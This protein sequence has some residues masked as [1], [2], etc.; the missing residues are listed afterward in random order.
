MSQKQSVSVLIGRRVSERWIALT[1]RSEGS[2]VR[3][4]DTSFFFAIRGLVSPFRSS[5]IYRNRPR[6][7]PVLR[8]RDGER[9]KVPYSSCTRD[10]FRAKWII[11]IALHYIYIFFLP[12]SLSLFSLRNNHLTSIMSAWNLPF[13]ITSDFSNVQFF[14]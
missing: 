2:S 10:C 1:T 14:F 12:Y 7:K 13:P 11:R 8:L 5:F 3:I 4:I 6:V 9:N